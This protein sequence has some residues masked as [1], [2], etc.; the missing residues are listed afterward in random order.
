MPGT[1][2]RARLRDLTEGLCHDVVNEPR[3]INHTEKFG[4]MSYKGSAVY[5]R[6]YNSSRQSSN[7]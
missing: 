6:A 3:I 2:L 7:P 5:P 1:G 4:V